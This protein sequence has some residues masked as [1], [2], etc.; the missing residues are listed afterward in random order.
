MNCIFCKKESSNDRSIEHIIPES[1][2]NEDHTLPKGIVCDKC[3]NYFARKIEG[4]LLETKYFKLLRSEEFLPNKKRRPVMVE[5]IING[6]GK[7]PVISKIGR[8]QKNVFFHNGSSTLDIE[9][10]MM[11]IAAASSEPPAGIMD[12]FLA[13]AALETLAL[14]MIGHPDHLHTVATDPQ[15]DPIRNF[16]RLATPK[17]WPY[18]QRVIYPR[19]SD[20]SDQVL[21]EFDL[22]YTAELEL[23]F[24][25][26]IFGVEYVINMGN[27]SIDG[28]QRWLEENDYIS[29]LYT[30]KNIQAMK[31]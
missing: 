17:S 2:G 24:V 3:N 19:H 21:H 7:K 15:L 5:A 27:P 6:Y 20:Q 23:Y 8:L 14:R 1:L 11:V 29:P 25:L 9:N 26:A 18:H 31:V 16:A 10:G 22:L 13:K 12:R 28:Y 30:E 4:P